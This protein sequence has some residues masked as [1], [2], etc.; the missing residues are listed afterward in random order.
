M[1]KIGTEIIYLVYTHLKHQRIVQNFS[2]FI[3]TVSIVSIHP[4]APVIMIRNSLFLAM[5]LVVCVCLFAC[6]QNNSKS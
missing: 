3:G 1:K 2:C 4:W 6:F 5:Q